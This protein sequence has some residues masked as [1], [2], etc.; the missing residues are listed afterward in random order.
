MVDLT[1]LFKIGAIIIFVTIDVLKLIMKEG[2][3]MNFINVQA[4]STNKPEHD[5]FAYEIVR[6]N[7]DL[8]IVYEEV[9]K[10]IKKMNDFEGYEQIEQMKRDLNDVQRELEHMSSTM[11]VAMINLVS[12]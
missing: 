9:T 8:A 10:F 11:Q 7:D 5:Q 12:K 1:I 4:H 3:E 2:N 6:K